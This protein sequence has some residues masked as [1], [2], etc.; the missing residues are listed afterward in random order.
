M[1][2]FGRA[3]PERDLYQASVRGYE[4]YAQTWGFGYRLE[5][6]RWVEPGAGVEIPHLN[7]MH[8][9]LNLAKAQLEVGDMG[10][11]WIMFV[12]LKY[13]C[14]RPLPTD[15]TGLQTPTVS[16]STPAYLSLTF[17]LPRSKSPLRLSSS[18]KTTMA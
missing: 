14:H 4:K 15:D 16:F 5:T 3:W 7:K 11:E 2:I 6:Q 1:G 17:S 8:A 18:I 13:T 12:P 10:A 9:V